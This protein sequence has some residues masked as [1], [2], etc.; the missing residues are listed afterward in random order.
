MNNIKG[1]INIPT[2]ANNAPGQT[3]IFGELSTNSSTFSRYK[4]NYAN[5]SLYPGVELVGFTT[6]NNVGSQ[7]TL[8]STISNHILSVASWVLAQY[9][10]SAV[11][12]NANKNL[13][14]S[15]LETQFPDMTDISINEIM[16]GTVTQRMPDYIDWLFNDGATDNRIK[17]W[18]AD[19]RFQSQYDDYEIMVIPPV[20]LLDNLNNPSAT[21]AG[22]LAAFTHTHFVNAIATATGN[23]PYTLL[24]TLTLVWH[25]PTLPN[26]TLNTTWGVV[27]YGSA[28]NDTDKIKATIR[29]YIA[30]NSA[31][32]VWSTLYPTLYAENEFIII[33]QWNSIA[34]PESG[35]DVALYSPTLKVSELLSMAPSLLPSSYA[36]AVV[37]TSYIMDNLIVSSAFW[38]SI[39]FLAIGNPGNVGSVFSLKQKFPDYMNVLTTSPDWGRMTLTTR[40]FIIA[41]NAALEQA[42]TLTEVSPV[43]VGYTRV[44][45]N[46]R[47]HLGFNY[48][49]FTYL[50]LAKVSFP[51]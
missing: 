26:A 37:L 43:P 29:A 2:L 7:I 4:S 21:V 28:G 51:V 49:G 9:N 35:L 32:T 48:D 13:F 41:L 42:L 18:F 19:S 20:G 38:R 34:S 14:I 17:I 1:F 44:M 36:T 50:V 23:L 16:A 33:P 47:V 31:L 45:I 12:T 5:P 39:G 30:A 27:I 6:K 46:N 22:F 40:N 25:D 15:Q 3:A 10:A 24:T 8:T 11:P